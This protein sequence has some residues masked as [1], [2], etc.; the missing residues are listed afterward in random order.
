MEITAP[1][2]GTIVR[3]DADVG[4]MITGGGMGSGLT[5]GRSS[6]GTIANL[7]RMDVETDVSETMLSRI[8]VGQPA[9]I[10]VSAVPDKRYRGKLRQII[11]ISDRARGTVK[12][13]VEVL[14]PEDRLFPELVATVHFLPDKAIKSPDSGKVQLFAPKAAIFEENGHSQVWVLGAKNTLRKTQ[15]DV[16]MTND[17]LARIESGLRVGDVVVVSPSKSLRDGEIAKVAE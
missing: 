2:D 8:A 4:E 13:M 7:A 1:F 6:V 14:E 16:V 10:S 5:N 15:V 3:K 11:P 12:V 17:D 9:E